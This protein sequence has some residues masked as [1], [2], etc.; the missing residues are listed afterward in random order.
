MET[1]GGFLSRVAERTLGWVALGAVALGGIAIYQMPAE[2][3]AAIWSGMWRT[4][5]WFVFAAALPWVGTFFIRR[6][7]Q[8]GSNWA[9]VAWIAGLVA[10]DVLVGVILMTVWPTGGWAWLAVFGVLAV[11]GT[12]NYLVTEYLAE[13]SGY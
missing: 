2:T 4:V 11:A 13:N 7:M 3:K 5:F 6:L 1:S 9:G 12:Y 8:T 10:A